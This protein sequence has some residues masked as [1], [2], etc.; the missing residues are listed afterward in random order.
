MATFYLRTVNERNID[1][2]FSHILRVNLIYNHTAKNNFH[3]G[4]KTNSLINS[5]QPNDW[6]QA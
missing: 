2:N 5:K 1:S 3:D 4:E 6:N